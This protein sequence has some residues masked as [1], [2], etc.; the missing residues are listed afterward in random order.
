M[1]YEQESLIILQSFPSLLTK[2]LKISL[3]LLSPPS[4]SF[5]S[6]C[7]VFWDLL[8]TNFTLYQSATMSQ[9]TSHLEIHKLTSTQ[10]W[11]SDRKALEHH[12][13]FGYVGLCVSTKWAWW[14]SINSAKEEVCLLRLGSCK[15]MYVEVFIM[16][17]FTSFLFIVDLALTFLFSNNNI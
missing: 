13:K 1:S 2:P 15:A 7:S 10:V 16:T 11:L 8:L 12:V 3:L 9:V 17:N 14:K 6:Q 4:S 5:L